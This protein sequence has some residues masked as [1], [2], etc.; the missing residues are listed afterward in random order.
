MTRPEHGTTPADE[1]TG[2]GSRELEVALR[3]AVELALDHEQRSAGLPADTDR[4]PETLASTPR[5]DTPT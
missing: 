4:E 2:A 1:I 3:R 5:P